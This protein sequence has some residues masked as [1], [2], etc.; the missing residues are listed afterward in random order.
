MDVQKEKKLVDRIN[1]YDR[2]SIACDKQPTGK[3]DR[4]HKARALTTIVKTDGRFDTWPTEDHLRKFPL[5]WNGL[6]N[7]T[8]FMMSEAYV[9]RASDGAEVQIGNIGQEQNTEAYLTARPTPD[10]W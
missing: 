1:H 8:I 9:G 5:L 4:M 7:E 10:M 2:M 3:V 6:Q